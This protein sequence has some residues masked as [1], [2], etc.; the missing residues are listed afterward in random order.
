MH[1]QQG[2]NAGTT[3]DG[4]DDEMVA[5]SPWFALDHIDHEFLPE[6]AAEVADSEPPPAIAAPPASEATASPSTPPCSPSLYSRWCVRLDPSPQHHR[7]HPGSRAW[8]EAPPASEAAT[9]SEE[10]PPASEPATGPRS[11]PKGR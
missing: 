9:A 2:T 5:P 6:V 10:E 7:H 4:G 11:R 1:V 8:E 3:S